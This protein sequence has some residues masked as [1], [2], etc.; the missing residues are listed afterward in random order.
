[1]KAF[2]DIRIQ[3]DLFHEPVNHSPLPWAGIS[4]TLSMNSMNKLR[5]LLRKDW[6]TQ[7]ESASLAA[8]VEYYRRGIMK[9][10]SI[11]LMLPYEGKARILS[12]AS[13]QSQSPAFWRRVRR[14]T[15]SGKRHD[16]F[17]STSRRRSKPAEHKPDMNRLNERLPGTDQNIKCSAQ[18]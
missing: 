7:V 18:V 11:R 5:A 2:L 15:P 10:T 12:I 14:L 6:I 4:Y 8:V 3:V 16:V 9:P 13:H 17:A 1:M